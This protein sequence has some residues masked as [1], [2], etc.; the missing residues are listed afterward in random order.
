MSPS[1]MCLNEQVCQLTLWW[2]MCVSQLLWQKMGSHISYD[3]PAET[4]L[5]YHFDP[6]AA[7]TN[8]HGI[9]MQARVVIG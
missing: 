5:V 1:I 7:L 6:G 8:S 4:D 3:C 9:L 2:K